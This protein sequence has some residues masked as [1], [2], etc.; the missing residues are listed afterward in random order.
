M[1]V[2][3]IAMYVPYP[4]QKF[5]SYLIYHAIYK[6]FISDFGKFK[7]FDIMHIYELIQ[8][9]IDTHLYARKGWVLRRF[10]Q[11]RSYRDIS[12]IHLR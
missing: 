7:L 12:S 2:D 6:W 9:T 3:A 10:Q 4:Y 5:Q 8:K 11:L 1:N